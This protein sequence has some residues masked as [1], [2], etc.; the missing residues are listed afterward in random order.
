[1][2]SESNLI[3][4]NLVNRA[5]SSDPESKSFKCFKIDDF[6]QPI[7]NYFTL[8]ALFRKFAMNR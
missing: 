3:N 7:R 1:M 2:K 4:N 8:H 5:N 6:K